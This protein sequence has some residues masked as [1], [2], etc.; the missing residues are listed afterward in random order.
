M[1]H[2][3]TGAA[4]LAGLIGWPV[5]HSLSPAIHNG[6]IAS[7]GL[8]A[9]YVPMAVPPQRLGE[10]VAGLAALGFAGANVTIPHKEAVMPLCAALDPAARAIGAVNTLVR[11]GDGF[12]GHNTDAAGFRASLDR[13]APGWPR[14]RALVLGAGGAGLACTFALIAAGVPEILIANRDPARAEALCRHLAR[15]GVTLRALP[16]ADR[17]AAL[18][19]A[20]LLVNATS[21]GMTGKPALD[22]ALDRLMPGAVVADVVYV[23]LATP[24]VADARARGHR[25]IGGLGMLIE[26]ARAA[27]ALWFGIDPQDPPGLRAALERRLEAR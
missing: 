6:W 24:L 17:A 9:A 23:P 4:R 22:L 3:I 2:A 27:F 25:A 16:W 8:D 20:A 10:A 7:A 1:T 18:G 11:Q 5:A 21:L 13:E 12:E 15:P 26:Q 19:D 14:T